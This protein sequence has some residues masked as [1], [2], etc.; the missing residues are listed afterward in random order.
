MYVSLIPLHDLSADL[1]ILLCTYL[2]QSLHA[3]ILVKSQA[4]SERLKGLKVEKK[5]L[6]DICILCFCDSASDH[7]IGAFEIMHLFC[8]GSLCW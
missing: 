4:F 1:I 5:V 7:C 3:H 8:L 2:S 6:E